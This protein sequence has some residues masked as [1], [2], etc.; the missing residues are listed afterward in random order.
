MSKQL[1]YL[2]FL[3]VAPEKKL[4]FIL[5]KSGLGQSGVGQ[6][7]VGQCGVGLCEVRLC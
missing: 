7:G 3:K 4:F 5:I 6:C 2:L 1:F